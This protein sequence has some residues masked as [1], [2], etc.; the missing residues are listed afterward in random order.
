MFTARK[1]RQVAGTTQWLPGR[2]CPLLGRLSLRVGCDSPPGREG[3]ERASRSVVCLPWRVLGPWATGTRGMQLWQGKAGSVRGMS[4]K[5]STGDW[6]EGDREQVPKAG[7]L[8]ARREAP[9]GGMTRE[10]AFSCG[11]SQ[12]CEPALSPPQGGRVSTLLGLP[13]TCYR[14]HHSPWPRWDTTPA[15]RWVV[16]RPNG[17]VTS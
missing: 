2:C 1:S 13:P 8:A 3:P 14:G 6:A 10:G 15:A 12:E 17:G 9:R 11:C 7:T 5:K 16:L 4:D